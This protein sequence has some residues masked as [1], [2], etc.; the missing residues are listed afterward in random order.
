VS[1]FSNGTRS[2][3]KNSVDRATPRATTTGEFFVGMP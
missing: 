2:H 1:S 3:T